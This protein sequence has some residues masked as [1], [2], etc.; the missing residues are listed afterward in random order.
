MKIIFTGDGADEIFG[1]YE[2]YRK[3]NIASK[4]SYLN[5][6]LPKIRRLKKLNYNQLPEFFYNNLNIINDKDLFNS[7]FLRNM[8]NTGKF[9]FFDN[10]FQNQIDSINFFDLSYWLTDESNFKLDRS[11]MLNSIEARVPFQ[12]MMA[13]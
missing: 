7:N 9:Q 12:D 11:S 2:R 13:K 3:C 6:I 4:L 10:L 5:L 1:G 8:T